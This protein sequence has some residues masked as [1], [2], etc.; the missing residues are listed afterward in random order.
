MSMSASVELQKPSHHSDGHGSRAE[1]LD[2]FSWA[3]TCISNG[4]AS[5][6]SLRHDY[7][8]CDLESLSADRKVD[9]SVRRGMTSPYQV[10]LTSARRR[11]AF[12]RSW[13]H[14]KHNKE[15]IVILR[16]VRSGAFALTQCGVTMTVCAGQFCFSKSN[17]PF[18]WESQSDGMS[19]SE[20]YSVLLPVDLVHRYFVSGVPMKNSLAAQAD[21]RLAMPTIFPLLV[22]QGQYLDHGVASMLV[23][24]VLREAQQMAAD[25]DA[26]IDTRKHICEKR[27]E[28]ILSYISLH[29]SNPDICASTVAKACGISQRYLCYLLKLKGTPFSELLWEERLKRTKEW[30]LVLDTRHYTISEIAYMNGFKTAAHF[31]RLFKNYWGCSPREYRKSGGACLTNP[32]KSLAGMATQ[33]SATAHE[34]PVA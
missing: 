22:D 19:L 15:N 20:F 13:E 12:W 5:V 27:T 28:D 11:Y 32:P 1:A 21:R 18:R 31:S 26:E 3:R 23:D 24:T 9:V 2:G 8:D 6:T 7:Y 25:A 34:E 14:M 30:L 33:A 29:L 10:S 17:V 16:Y 4:A